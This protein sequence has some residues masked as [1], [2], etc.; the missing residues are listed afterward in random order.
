MQLTTEQKISLAEEW[1]DISEWE[2][3]YQ[4]SNLGRVK[5]LARR[6]KNNL[7]GHIFKDE[8]IRRGRIDKNGYE[9]IL[10]C[11]DGKKNSFLIH[12]L[13]A[14]HFIGNPENKPQ[15]NHIDGNKKN[16]I[17]YN[18]EWVT[19]KE[20]CAHAINTGLYKNKNHRRS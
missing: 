4:I 19:E 18:L 8:N 10:L 20:N 9:N 7:H 17:L 15:V 16:N 2:G 11:R 13:V 6:V 14:I 12:R 1:R 3:L 5:S